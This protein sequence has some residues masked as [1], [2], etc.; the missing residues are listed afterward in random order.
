M[1]IPEFKEKLFNGSGEIP[2]VHG[3]Q[4]WIGVSYA[5]DEFFFLSSYLRVTIF[6]WC[7][8]EKAWKAGFD[9]DGAAQFGWSLLGTDVWIGELY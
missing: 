2:S 9:P 8:V 1:Q 6:S 5:S 3:L 4:S 7:Y